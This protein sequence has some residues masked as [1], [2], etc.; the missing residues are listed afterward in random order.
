MKKT[1][2][3]ILVISLLLLV[4]CQEKRI[5]TVT[6]EAEFEVDPDQVEI[7]FAI[8]TNATEAK[9][10]QTENAEITND[11]LEALKNIGIPKSDL[12]TL[13]YNIYPITSWDDG[14]QTQ[15]GFRATNSIKVTS[16]DIDKAG[17]IIDAAVKAGANR[18]QNIHFTLSDEKQKE[19]DAIAMQQAGEDAKDKAENI[20]AGLGLRLGKITSFQESNVYAIP[21]AMRTFEDI[22]VA[23]ISEKIESTPILPSKVTV[24]AS[25]TVTYSII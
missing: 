17:D 15:E 3:T 7:M 8:Q 24:R 2:L 19:Q 12:E 25:I 11:V 9:D 16:N 10:V 18:I 5:A 22:E 6:G 1:I 20:A 4:G 21:Y 13:N 14:K 23:A